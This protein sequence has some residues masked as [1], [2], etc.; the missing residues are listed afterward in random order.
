MMKQG[1]LLLAGFVATTL[2]IS[3][4]VL[5]QQVKFA[6]DAEFYSLDRSGCIS[7]HVLLFVRNGKTNQS[8]ESAQARVQMTALR[9][10]ECQDQILLEARAMANLRNGEVSFDQQLAEV[11]LDATVPVRDR[12][13]RNAFDAKVSVNW[14]AVDEPVA[15]SARFEV[16]A[17][18]RIERRARA[19]ATSLRLA[20]ASGTI[21][22]DGIANLIPEPSTD[23]AITSAR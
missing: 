15:L 7:S 13:S 14:V 3:A 16:E 22:L 1:Q 2:V 8:R 10:D 19:V 4:P 11:T 18:G 5:A 12:T 9:I 21:A 20:E 6:A 23:A 17:P